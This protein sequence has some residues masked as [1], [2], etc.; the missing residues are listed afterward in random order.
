MSTIEPL[1]RRSRWPRWAR[2]GLMENIATAI[3]AIGFL[4][5]FQPFALSL[6]SYSFVTMLA[7]TAMF[8][9]VSKFPE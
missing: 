5:L 8:I 4:M 6:Y 7:G 3:I 1:K 2:R 9:I